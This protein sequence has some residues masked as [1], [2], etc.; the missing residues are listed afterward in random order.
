[1]KAAEVA[2]DR[3]HL[4]TL[5]ELSRGLFHDL[6]SP[7]SSIT[8]VAEYICAYADSDPAGVRDCAETLR[9]SCRDLGS[10]VQTIR[11]YLANPRSSR[12]FSLREQ[13]ERAGMLLAH[14]ARRAGGVEIVT[15]GEEPAEIFARPLPVLQVMVNL[16]ANGID[17]CAARAASPSTPVDYRGRVAVSTAVKDDLACLTI[18]D[19]GI[20]MSEETAG[21]AFEPHFSTKDRGEGTGIGLSS[22]RMITQDILGGTISLETAPDEGA[23]FYIEFPVAGGV[24]E[25]DVLE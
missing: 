8:L 7:L 3:D 16:I 19:N 5:G 13:A 14:R 4:A 2:L 22:V 9:R 18:R 1:M 6:A 23:I 20:G 17:A 12:R 10:L 15:V 24:G 25:P 21:R 11:E